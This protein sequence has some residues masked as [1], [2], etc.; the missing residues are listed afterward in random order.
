MA[1]AHSSTTS[2][3]RLSSRLAV[4]SDSRLG[5]QRFRLIAGPDQ[6]TG[7]VHGRRADARAGTNGHAT[8]SKAQP[9]WAA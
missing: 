7:G 3:T 5:N 1:T 4:G 8:E 6:E 2:T 9:D